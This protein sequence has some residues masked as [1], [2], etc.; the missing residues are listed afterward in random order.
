MFLF[1]LTFL[2]CFQLKRNINFYQWIQ[3]KNLQDSDFQTSG[4][5]V[6][7]DYWF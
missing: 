1:I 4:L 3:I 6:G 7:V 5:Q 2:N